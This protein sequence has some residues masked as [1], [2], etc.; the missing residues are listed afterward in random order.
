MNG[1][2]GDLPVRRTR[3][4]PHAGVRVEVVGGLR[5]VY[6]ISLQAVSDGRVRHTAKLSVRSVIF[7]RSPAT[8]LNV[9]EL[10][11]Q[12]AAEV[13]WR[14]ALRLRCYCSPTEVGCKVQ[15]FQVRCRPGMRL[16]SHPG[17]HHTQR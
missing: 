12:Y 7:S 11:K 13:P 17:R 16:A 10:M 4:S 14:D 9:D 2:H 3:G 1:L 6:I 15:G 5:R 8:L